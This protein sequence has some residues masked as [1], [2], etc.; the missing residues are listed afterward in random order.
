[1]ASNPD[2]FTCGFLE[3]CYRRGVPEKV[4][5]SLLSRAIVKAAAAKA[6]IPATHP[7]LANLG[8]Q[9]LISKL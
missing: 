9:H 3:E 2:P 4:A 1:M 5:A 6:P 8:V 7:V